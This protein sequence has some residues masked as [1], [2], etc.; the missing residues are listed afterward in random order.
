MNLWF[1]QVITYLIL[2]LF[3]LQSTS[4]SSAPHTLQ[5]QEATDQLPEF[6]CPPGVPYGPVHF[7]EY[8]P[9]PAYLEF[10]LEEILIYNPEARTRE[11]KTGYRKGR[12][13]TISLL[14]FRNKYNYLP[15]YLVPMTPPLAPQPKRLQESVAANE[16]TSTQIFGVMYITLTG[17]IDFMVPASGPWAL[18]GKLLS[19]I[20]KL[21]PILW[22]AL[23]AGPAGC[24]PASSQE[25]LTGWI[26]D[27]NGLT[28][29]L[30]VFW[31]TS[32]TCWP[33]RST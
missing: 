31:I 26:S 13:I 17:L 20:V 22:W 18:L 19:Y 6:Y 15:V 12:K 9:N 1:N 11:T 16:S 7:T 33:P 8:P 10:T 2:V 21:A 24:P 27:T 5:P 3:H 25:P 29:S 30:C 23:P 32:M 14:L 28:A 4:H